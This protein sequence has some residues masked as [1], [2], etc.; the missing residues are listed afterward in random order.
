MTAAVHRLCYIVD[1]EA[2]GRRL[3]TAQPDAQERLFWSLE[4][5][6]GLAGVRLSRC[7]E[8][9]RG[10][11]KLL[12]LPS[13]IDQGHA[14]PALITG[15][16]DALYEAN[17]IPGAA[18]RIRLR[19][20]LTQGVV[21]VGPTGFVG[22]SIVT[23]CYLLDS[24]AAHQALAAAPD[25]DTMVIVTEDLYRDVFS[26]GFIGGPAFCKVTVVRSQKSFSAVGWIQV[27]G[28][29]SPNPR[30]PGYQRPRIVLRTAEQRRQAKIFGALA[31]LGG[32][33]GAG[34]YAGYAMADSSGAEIA[35][36]D[37]MTD[38]SALDAGNPPDD[39]IYLDESH[40]HDVHDA[41]HD[42][43]DDHHHDEMHDGLH[44]SQF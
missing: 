27:P 14:L 23:G 30:I 7:D 17:R 24:D 32:A 5:A 21:E 35:A 4:H 41:G 37:D 20:A 9:D 11:G 18:G 10:D 34:Y 1:I 12:V 38:P 15:M 3:H 40:A 6:F 39:E 28:P 16:R 43:H 29:G 26:Q 31:A 8:Q 44:D 19:T 33:G 2:Y 22:Q 25:S 42:S 13:G 36:D